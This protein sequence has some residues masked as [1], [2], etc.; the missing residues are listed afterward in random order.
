MPDRLSF[1]D[2]VNRREWGDVMDSAAV[3]V[4]APSSRGEALGE[5]LKDLHTHRHRVQVSFCSSLASSLIGLG[6]G[7]HRC[8]DRDANSGASMCLCI[9]MTLVAK[10]PI[11]V[12]ATAAL[13]E[14]RLM[15]ST[16]A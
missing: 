9:T 1:G 5:R 14:A 16:S 15:L 3:S 8:L 11:P 2:E 12:R 6:P 10:Q 4:Q 7:F 13:T